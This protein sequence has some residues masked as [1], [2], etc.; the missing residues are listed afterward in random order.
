MIWDLRLL[1]ARMAAMDLLWDAPRLRV[2]AVAKDIPGPAP[3]KFVGQILEPPARWAAERAEMDRL[4]VRG[5]AVE[6]AP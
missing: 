1:L 5:S 6:S 4:I 3:V 2:A